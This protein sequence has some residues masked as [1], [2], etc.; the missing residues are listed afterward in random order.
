M[1]FRT[2]KISQMTPKGANLEATDLIEVSTIESGSYVTRSITG[3]EIIDA[4]V[5][6]VDW[7]DIGGTLSA[8]TDLQNALDAKV[9]TSRTL[10]INGVTQ[11]L[12]ANRTFT[13]STGIT[14]GTTAIASGVV[15]RVLFEG[16]GNVVQ[17]SSSLFWDA[18]NNRLGIGTETPA[19]KLHIKAETTSTSA[20][21]IENPSSGSV[22]LPTTT[23]VTGLNQTTAGSNNASYL[24]MV[25][26][27]GSGT[28][29]QGPYFQLNGNLHTA[30]GGQRGYMQFAS[31][32]VTSPTGNDG[33]IAF[34]CASSAIDFNTA[35]TNKLSIQNNGN[36]LINTTTDAGFRLDV[37][38]TA[39][40]QGQ[41]TIAGTT[42]ASAGLG[43]NTLINGTI[44]ATANNNVLVGL[45]IEPTFNTGAFTGVETLA[46]RVTGFISNFTSSGATQIRII[47]PSNANKSLFFFNS[48]S[49]FAS[50]R[51]Y[52]QG[53]TNH[54]VF[55]T[56][57][58]LSNP[59]DRFAIFAS[60]GN[61][62]I[63]TTTDAGFRLDV[64]GTAR[65]SGNTTITGTIN[66]GSSTFLTLSGAANSSFIEG[67]QSIEY[68]SRGSSAERRYHNFTNVSAFNPTIDFIPHVAMGASFAPTSGTGTYSQLYL[69][70][71]INQTGGANGITRGLHI[72]PTLTAAADF[73]AIETTAGHVIFGNLPTSPAG[74]PTGA[75]YNNL[76]VLMIV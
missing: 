32:Q 23:Y 12:S 27:P 15:G 29:S 35:G 62:G 63:N 41:T 33:K 46:L 9:P 56:G 26:G 14:I 30:F 31:G 50:T 28:P 60:T 8:Q 76:G 64:N 48:S 13:I 65:V 49:T 34:N 59:T 25:A 18:T 40:V 4:A 53:T 67:N 72:V 58:S 6:N 57:D 16:A 20:I 39:R 2:Q 68:R 66:I 19:T 54:L 22:Y 43:R 7:G 3:Q 47:G 52:N 61:V 37:N 70:P 45:D 71:T 75:I 24:L 10:T 21:I 51:I 11:D 1:A 36:V 44:T 5:G 38:G 17:E 42:N 73:R 55:A 69:T 74:L